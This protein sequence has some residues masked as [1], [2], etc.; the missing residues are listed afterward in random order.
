MKIKI[1]VLEDNPQ[2][3]EQILSTLKK[4]AQRTEHLV[5]IN[6]FKDE[7][8]IDRF[9]HDNYNLLFADIDLQKTCQNSG[10][11]ICK[12]LRENG[13]SQ[14]IIFLTAFSEYVFDGYD[15]RALNY[16]IKPVS[17]DTIS[18][19]MKKYITIHENKYYYLQ[20]RSILIQIRINDIIYIQKEGHC[21]LFHT[22]SD[23]YYERGSLS[24][25]LTQLPSYFFQC[26]K[27]CIINIHHVL[28]IKGY[29]IYL[30]DNS[31]QSIGRNY[32]SN[33]RNALLD[34]SRL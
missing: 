27:S 23:D 19:V 18:L 25:I 26:H 22:Q 3:F 4:W 9:K 5:E 2:D 16:L 21:I 1:A 30:S 31:T 28:S 11:N 10:L 17:D 24:N 33:I 14:E 6:R 32:L 29:T 34:L 15:V 7:K 12:K 8:I 13:Y 20:D